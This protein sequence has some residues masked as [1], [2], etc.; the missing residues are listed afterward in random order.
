M[1]LEAMTRDGLADYV[2]AQ[3]DHFFPDGASGARAAIDRDLDEALHRIIHCIKGVRMWRPESFDYLHS[4]QYTIFLYYLANTIW[5]NRQDERLCTKLFY[6]NKALNGIDCF[7]AIDMPDIWFIGH[8][9]GI[10]FSRT[11]Y[12]NYFAVYQNATVGKSHGA[13]PVLGECVLMYPNTAI[14][15]DCRIAPRTYLAQG[16]SVINQDTP[17]NAIAFQNGPTL[18]FRKPKHDIIADIFRIDPQDM[19]ETE[20]QALAFAGETP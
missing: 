3:L 4:S 17:G 14:I 7:Y 6:L 20:D 8:S 18:T 19:K 13:A 1:N 9:V 2:A 12:G 5:R 10:V 16:T 15:G 11:T